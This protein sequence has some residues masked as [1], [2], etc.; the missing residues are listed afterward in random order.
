MKFVGDEIITEK[1]VLLRLDLN[2][3]IKNGTVLDTTKI[4]K[5][6]KTIEYLIA[7]NNTII[8]LSHLGRV[9]TKE[10]FE[11]CTLKPVCDYLEKRLNQKIK[12][13]NCVGAET[14]KECK[15]A[16]Y[17]EVLM[18]ENV[19]FCDVPEK[20]ESNNDLFIAKFWSSMGDIFVNDAFATL[21]RPH[22]SVAGISNYLPTYFGFLVKEEIYNL[23]P[24]INN[25]QKPFCV[26]MGG[27][28]VD[29]KLG[30]IKGL[31]QKCDYLLVGGGIANSFL[32]ALGYDIKDS[33]A[34]SDQIT[35]DEIKELYKT[36]QNKIILPVDFMFENN[37]ILD[38]G[39]ESIDKY[40]TYL[41]ESKTIFI[42]GTV[43]KFEDPR[44][45]EGTRSF[46]ESLY[47]ID[48]IKIAGGGDTV[49]AINSL[50]VKDAFTYISS[51]GGAALEYI[52][53][54]HL[55]AIDYIL[56]K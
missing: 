52:S 16:K 32:L 34:T 2:V 22:A 41:K 5:S 23:E 49:N 53:S 36:Y 7:N 25:I 28:K 24:L 26:F 54:N 33:L 42:N 1:R 27:A 13:L 50:G 38:L 17:K 40:I 35:L 37:A 21:H 19:R 29:D 14:I 56:R 10:D 12:F 8:I 11:D 6:L 51:G 15:E 45:L 44:F 39:K 47:N 3:P 46:F 55:K 9:K 43:G 18:L 31:L 4:D 30:Y 20:L 48:A